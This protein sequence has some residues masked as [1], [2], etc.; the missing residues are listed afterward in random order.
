[1]KIGRYIGAFPLAS[2]VLFAFH[3]SSVEAQSNFKV[4][5]DGDYYF[6]AGLVDHDRNAGYRNTEFRNRLR[7]NFRPSGMAD[8]GLEYGARLRIRA[9]STA[10]TIDEDMSYIYVSGSFGTLQLG[11]TYN[12]NNL[13]YA[14]APIDYRVL[15]IPDPVQSFVTTSGSPYGNHVDSLYSG[16]INSLDAIY[17]LTSLSGTKAFYMTP[18]F[19]GVHFGVQYTPNNG[20]ANTDVARMSS[21]AAA[22]VQSRFID[23]WE[24]GGYYDGKIADVNLRL[25]GAYTWGRAADGITATGNRYEDL[26]A[27]QIGARATYRGFTLGG[28]YVSFGKSG[29]S[30]ARYM[31]AASAA[32]TPTDAVTAAPTFGGTSEI[33][34]LGVQYQTGPLMVGTMV[35]R[36]KDPGALSVRGNR[37]LDI[38]TLGA[39]YTVAP[40]FRVGAEWDH[41]NAKSD[42]VDPTGA[43]RDDK[44]NLLLLRSVLVF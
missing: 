11:N 36:G 17:L 41:F 34:N 2:F 29:Q 12:Y 27:Y 7:L 37:T 40:G 44:G 31:T 35:S 18:K 39:M 1:M 5:I 28:G 30:K 42:L 8:N 19:G 16:G 26:K 4:T 9:N 22:Q 10:R 20:S 6:E 32:G 24:V 21:V 13:Y 14:S 15:G 25:S 38:Y 33:W 3:T 23:I 43:K